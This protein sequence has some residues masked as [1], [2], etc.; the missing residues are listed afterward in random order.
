LDNKNV[1]KPI[2][3]YDLLKQRSA[4]M[5][6]HTTHHTPH[7]THHTPHTTHHTLQYGTRHSTDAA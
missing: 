7:T 2:T 5:L 6:H 4:I 3:N 1:T